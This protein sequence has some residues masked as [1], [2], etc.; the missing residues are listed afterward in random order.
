M[1]YYILFAKKH[2]LDFAKLL[3]DPKVKFAVFWG[4]GKSKCW[5]FNDKDCNAGTL[6]IRIAM[7]AREI[8]DILFRRTVNDC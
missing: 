2:W 1:I 6:M 7:L 5:N 8:D 3:V 4:G